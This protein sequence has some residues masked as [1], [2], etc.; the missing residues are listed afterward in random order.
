MKRL[1]RFT[2]N[3]RNADGCF[4]A[5]W[6]AS[7]SPAVTGDALSDS[8]APSQARL[9]FQALSTIRPALLP[10]CAMREL[11]VGASSISATVGARISVAP[12][13]STDTEVDRSFDAVDLCDVVDLC[14]YSTPVA[15]E[16]AE[17]RR[18][19]V[20]AGRDPGWD[21]VAATTSS[22]VGSGTSRGAPL[23]QAGLG[24]PDLPVSRLLLACVFRPPGPAFPCST[25]TVAH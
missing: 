6:L 21:V 16:A 2:H 9:A 7:G 13:V 11:G 22:M 23:G 18:A 10:D 5:G 25:T 8:A 14:A 17:G 24:D 19:L 1:F 4:G 20:D 15:N 3:R 12:V